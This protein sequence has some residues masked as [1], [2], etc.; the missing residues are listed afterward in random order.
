MGQWKEEV[1]QHPK[2]CKNTLTK[3]SQN[4]NGKSHY[5]KCVVQV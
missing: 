2:H 4:L 3:K 5:Q 1:M